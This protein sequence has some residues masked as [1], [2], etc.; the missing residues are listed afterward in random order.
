M[1]LKHYL[2]GLSIVVVIFCVGSFC[3]IK[4]RRMMYPIAPPMPPVVNQT[5][6]EILSQLEIVLKSKAPKILDQMQPGLSEQTINE[7]EHQ[8]GVQLS[9]EIKVLYKWHDGCSS[10]NQ[11]AAGP[12]PYH[13]FLPLEETL[14]L[15]NIVSNQVASATPVQGTAFKVFAGHTQTWITLFD[16][17]AGDGYFFDPNR[18]PSE[19]AVF[20]HMAEEGYYVFFPS[21]KNLLAGVLKCYEQNAFSWEDRT[22]G[23]SLENDF[24]SSEKIWNEFGAVSN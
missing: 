23:S 17:G 21:T 4:F 7:L 15:N 11:T 13:R 9:D 20:Y 24:K 6:E 3:L 1:K 10:S 8:A 22:N 5:T 19:G 2:I 14:G 16:D 12:I 18:K